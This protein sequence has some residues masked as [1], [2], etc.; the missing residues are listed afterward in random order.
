V[1]TK[2]YH[3]CHDGG[4]QPSVESLH[5]TLLLILQ[6]FDDVF[7][8]LDALD[9]CVE[10]KELL[11]WIMEMTSWRKGK[12]RLL[13]TS[14][15]VEG[16]AKYLR[17][18]DPGHVCMMEDLITYDIEKYIDSILHHDDA[19]ERWDDGVKATIKSKLLENAGG[20]YAC[21][22]LSKSYYGLTIVLCSRFRLV[23]LQM[24]EL[25]DC[26]NKDDLESQLESLPRSLDEVYN[27]IVSEINTKYREDAL[28][29]L[30]WLSFSIRPLKLAEMAQV[31]CM[32]PDADQ[33]LR[34]KPSR[35]SVDPRSVLMICSS[36]V[37]EIDGK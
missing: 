19:F 35:V 29:I 21:A 1:L 4:S 3:S 37:T 14:R 26:L 31:T 12:L 36:F 28:K 7:V 11:K 25:Q 5:A 30:Q 15:P 20:M 2:L 16:I 24:N 9:E 33:G 10:R 32:V 17:S 18:L 8:I 27:R 23:S 13:A 34:F 22:N 6:A